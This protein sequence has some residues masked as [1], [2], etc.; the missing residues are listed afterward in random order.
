MMVDVILFHLELCYAFLPVKKPVKIAIRKL[1]N[2]FFCLIIVRFNG[3][4]FQA[5]RSSKYEHTDVR[6]LGSYRNSPFVT[7]RDDK[8]YGLRTE[9]LDYN[10]KKWKRVD[11]Y[12]YSNGDR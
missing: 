6:A 11:D 5:E 10:A 7:G 12:P 3:N 2:I 4:T 9:I 8:K 1:K